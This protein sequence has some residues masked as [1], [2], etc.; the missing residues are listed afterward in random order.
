[1]KRKLVRFADLPSER[2][3]KWCSTRVPSTDALQRRL[4]DRLR[5]RLVHALHGEYRVG[6]AVRDL[7]CSISRLKGHLESLFTPGMAWDNYGKGSDKWNID[8]ITPLSSV[9]LTDRTQLLSVCHYTNLQ[10][11]WETDNGKKGSTVGPRVVVDL[12][13]FCHA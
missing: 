1:M 3:D 13:E 5:Q 7:G 10:P 8:H 12:V 11:M 6:S 9:D 4:A 2:Q